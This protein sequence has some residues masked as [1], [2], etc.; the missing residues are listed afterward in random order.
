MSKKS[1]KSRNQLAIIFLVLLIA[2]II[3]QVR[4]SKQGERSFNPDLMDF[5]EEDIQKIRIYSQSSGEEPFVLSSENDV[6]IIDY[7]GK[8]YAADSDMVDNMISEL[9]SIKAVQKVA[10]SKEKWGDYDVTDSTGSRVVVEGD[11]KV[12]GDVYIG[13]FSFNQTTRMPKT[14]VRL[15]KEKDVFAVEGYLSMTFNRGLD[16]FRNKS[17]FR[18]N[19]NDLT[20]ISFTYPDSSFVLTKDSLGWTMNG[21]EADSASIAGYLGTVSYLTGTQ[22]RDDMEPVDLAAAPFSV[23]IEG[24][25]MSSVEIKAIRDEEGKTV[26]MSNANPTTLFDGE[27]GNLFTKVFVGPG[28]FLPNPKE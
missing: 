6:W 7:R 24:H 22:F 17:L 9:A 27:S 11:K 2:V 19:R 25:N 21:Q 1:K 20:Q 4:Q 10:A 18:G 16:G 28:K 12:L 23:V 14:F 3:V 8:N 15:N 13:R 5:V 26:M